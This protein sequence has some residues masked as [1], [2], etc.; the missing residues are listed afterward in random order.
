MV[1]SLYNMKSPAI[2]ANRVWRNKIG[3]GEEIA[4]I[5]GRQH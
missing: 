3:P 5:S 2:A 1:R 4:I